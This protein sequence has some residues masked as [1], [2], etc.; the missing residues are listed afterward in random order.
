M[1]RGHRIYSSPF[2]D[3]LTLSLYLLH[4]FPRYYILSSARDNK[5]RVK[6]DTY[7]G[8]MASRGDTVCSGIRGVRICKELL[9]IGGGDLR[10][11]RMCIVA[12]VGGSGSKSGWC[13][14]K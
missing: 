5:Q 7:R 4:C 10:W 3:I 2:H 9:V 6:D 14:K 12:V 1:L 11:R 8:A 13:C